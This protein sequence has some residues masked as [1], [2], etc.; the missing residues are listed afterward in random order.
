[1]DLLVLGGT[2]YLGRYVTQAA[3]ARRHRVTCVARGSVRL[4]PEG[5]EL[6]RADRD[7]DG[8][9]APVAGRP[10]DSVIDVARH[11]G[12]VRRAVAGLVATTAHYVFVSTGNVYADHRRP[13]LDESAPTLP[14]LA[15]EV[16]SDMSEYGAA[17]VACEDHVVAG[18]GPG[19]SLIARSGL[20]GGPDDWSGRSGYWPWRF[21]HPSNPEG[22]VLVPDTPDL[23][24]QVI[25]V[26]DLA[27]WLVQ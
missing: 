21:A 17:K 15:G 16:M 18:F 7:R 19:H 23:S 1:M 9:L 5:A 10:W 4:P 26:R 3:L 27:Q 12:Q 8:A 2:A 14:P 13:G 11:P 20:I 6:V 22:R 25:D 24:T